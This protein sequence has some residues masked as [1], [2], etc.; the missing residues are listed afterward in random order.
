[1]PRGLRAPLDGLALDGQLGGR[2]R[3]AVDTSAPLGEGAEV[4]GQLAGAC[5]V[6]AEP[7]GAD[8]T[9]LQAAR[10]HT[11]PDGSRAA[12]GPGVGSWVELR[13]LP[14]HVDG[15]F[16][17]AED[18]RF[19]EHRGFDLAQIARSLEIDLREG[20][21]ARGGSTIS[22]HLIKNAFLDG[23][24]SAAR[25]LSE[26]VLTW[27]LE[28]RL[29]K[30]EILE[31]YLNVIELGPSIYGLAAAA[32]HWF[33]ESPAQLTVRQAAFLAALTPEPTTMTRRI[34]AA[35]GLD[36]ASAARVETVLRAMKR[37][38]LLDEAGLELARRADLGFRRDALRP[39]ATATATA[40][41]SEIGRAS[42]RER[43]S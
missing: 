5:R 6:L 22:Q 29:S 43:V 14:A 19:F 37:Q 28:A 32:Q 27:R 34:I 20:R 36:R 25:K 41:A 11:F 31:R 7:P 13:R 8:V 15:A 39:T 35:G 9:S 42:C 24:R 33:G 16:V 38:G 4:T 23:R 10:E 26:A 12:V 30:R 40:S 21:L 18:A 1:V 2:A 3:V 17:A